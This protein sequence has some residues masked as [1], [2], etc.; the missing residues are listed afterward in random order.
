MK[1]KQIELNKIKAAKKEKERIEKIA[2]KQKIN[3]E[4]MN[5]LNFMS[6]IEDL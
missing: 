4:S 3:V 5:K 1:E 6:M 2:K